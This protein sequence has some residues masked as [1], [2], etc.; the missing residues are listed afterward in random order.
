MGDAWVINEKA[1]TLEWKVD[2]KTLESPVISWQNEVYF[3]SGW[4]FCTIFYGKSQIILPVT[5]TFTKH[6]RQ[7]EED[8]ISS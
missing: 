8:K 1:I 7:R 6:Q 5:Y 2:K 3:V 4:P